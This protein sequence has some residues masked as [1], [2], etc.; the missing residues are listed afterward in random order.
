MEFEKQSRYWAAVDSRIWLLFFGNV[1]FTLL[2]ISLA[3]WA[4]SIGALPLPS[5]IAALEQKSTKRI[6]YQGRL[7]D[8]HGIPLTGSYNM[9]FRLY[10]VPMGGT[11][12]WEE[13]WTSDNSVEVSDGLLNVMLGTIN[14][15]LPST[16]EGHDEL[17]LGVTVGN[18]IELSPRVPLGSVPFSMQALT[19]PDG[20]VTT[21][22][23]ADG[24]V[25]T[26]KLNVDNG[27]SVNGPLSVAGGVKTESLGRIVVVHDAT[28]DEVVFPF[29]E[30]ELASHV[31]QTFIW[32]DLGPELKDT[33][34]CAAASHANHRLLD[35]DDVWTGMYIV[36]IASPQVVHFQWSGWR[37]DLYDNLDN[38]VAQGHTL[39]TGT[40]WYGNGVLRLH[41]MSGIVGITNFECW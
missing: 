11:P 38:L 19:V 1:I 15:S 29:R 4:Q 33:T 12:L 26:A 16:I 5:W 27:L 3:F 21:E 17:Y 40:L 8:A 32:S 18:D 6:P 10:D 36:T 31:G 2:A 41:H 14:N 35:G 28:R 30:A 37:G 24:A 25:T 13:M 22:K 39:V 34:H 23:I 20:S 9:E 7:T